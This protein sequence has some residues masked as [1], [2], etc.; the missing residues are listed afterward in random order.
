MPS[1]P[2]GERD[3]SGGEAGQNNPTL[4]DTNET[5]EEGKSLY[6]P[7]QLTAARAL[8]IFK[9]RPQPS[10]PGQLR[11][12]ATAIA[13]KFKVSAKTVREIWA[14]RAWRHATCHEW[15]KAEATRASSLS[16]IMRDDFT[17]IASN[18]S[19]AVANSQPQPGSIP[20]FQHS[21]PGAL[22]PSTP[23][24]KHQAPTLQ[25]AP[26]LGLNNGAVPSL[27]ALLAAAHA[28]GLQQV[29]PAPPQAH[30]TMVSAAQLL[31]QLSRFQ[32]PPPRTAWGS[33]AHTGAAAQPAE[34]LSSTVRSLRATL[35]QLQAHSARHNHLFQQQQ[36]QAN[37]EP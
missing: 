28:P 2:E 31:A 5:K 14:G 19:D 1:T 23:P 13:P 11:R 33:V 12:G 25:V 16:F 6:Y 4:S 3:A 36:P 35:A 21:F 26:L 34:D 17:A 18:S 37:P 30:T 7:R 8:K 9:L 10:G 22:G 20:A 24:S 29:Q 27:Q 15:D 32:P